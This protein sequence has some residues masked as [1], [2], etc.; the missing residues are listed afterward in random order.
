MVVETY[1]IDIYKPIQLA[2]I[3]CIQLLVAQ[4]FEMP[5]GSGVTPVDFFFAHNIAHIIDQTLSFN[6]IFGFGLDWME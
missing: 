6:L 3:V 5:P 2:S 1:Y 4:W